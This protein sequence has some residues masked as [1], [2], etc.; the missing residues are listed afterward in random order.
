MSWIDNQWVAEYQVQREEGEDDVLYQALWKVS[1]YHVLDVSA[2]GHDTDL[3]E[4]NVDGSNRHNN[5]SY[6]LVEVFWVFCDILN[7]QDDANT[8]IGIN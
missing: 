7:R 3:T 4:A 1:S 8:L 6:D 5:S 2:I